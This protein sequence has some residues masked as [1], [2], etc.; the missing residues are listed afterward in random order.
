[1]PIVHIMLM[2]GR[3]EEQKSKAAAAITKALNEHLNAT[4]DHTNVVFQD[5]APAN[6]AIGGALLSEKKK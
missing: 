4:P 1:M 5:V 3:S 2:Q 6:W